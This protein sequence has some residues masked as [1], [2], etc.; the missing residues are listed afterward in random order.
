MKHFIVTLSFVFISLFGYSTDNII[1]PDIQTRFLYEFEH[2]SNVSWSQVKDFYKASFTMDGR[3]MSAFYNADG[4]LIAVTKNISVAE[5]PETLA[6]NLKKE[7]S[8]AWLSELFIM[9]TPNGEAYF[10]NIENGTTT[11]VLEA[12]M[13]RKWSVYNKS[14]K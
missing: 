12:G 3:A 2:A 10:A 5:L 11:T 1:S 7:L 8:N 14:N 9:S 6:N 13:T 4:E